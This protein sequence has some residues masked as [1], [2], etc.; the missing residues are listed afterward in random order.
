MTRDIVEELQAEH[1]SMALLLDVLDRHVARFEASGEPDYDLMQQILGYF[2]DFPN[3][4]HHPKEDLLAALLLERAPARAEPLRG[5][6]GRHEE[7]A[8]LTRRFANLLQR[9]LDEAELPRA[10]LVR[11]AREFIASQRHHMDAEDRE[12]LPLARDTLRL[13]DLAA[14]ESQL[15]ARQDPLKDFGG[16]ER[17]AKLRDA[18]LS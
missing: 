4:F 3:R 7:L 6:A 9:V 5:L 2:Q 8:A 12:F 1:R 13:G 14:L 10:E 11:A 16:E 18:L 17:Y 15:F